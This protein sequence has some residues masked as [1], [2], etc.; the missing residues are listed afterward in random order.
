MRV[1]AGAVFAAAV[2]MARAPGAEPGEIRCLTGNARNRTDNF[3]IKG[4]YSVL[5]PGLAAP[6][7]PEGPAQKDVSFSRGIL[8]DG[9]EDTL[10][11]WDDGEFGSLGRDVVVDLGGEYFL[12]R[13]EVYCQGN[14][15]TGG[16]LSLKQEEGRVFVPVRKYGRDDFPTEADR[17]RGRYLAVLFRG[18]NSVARR[19]RVNVRGS[20]TPRFAE[21]QIWGRAVRAG[22]SRELR[23]LL[24]YDPAKLTEPRP[25]EQVKVLRG[26]DAI[27]PRPRRVTQRPGVFR[28]SAGPRVRKVRGESW[29]RP[30]GYK[31]AVGM[32][33]VDLSYFDGAGHVHGRQT[34]A[35][36]ASPDGAIPCCEII[37]W[38]EFDFRAV[39]KAPPNK[40]DGEF[41]ERY[42]RAVAALKYNRVVHEGLSWAVN[43]DSWKTR[44]GK[45]IDVTELKEAIRFKQSLGM[46]VTGGWGIAPA[47]WVTY[48]GDPKLVEARPGEAY[49]EKGRIKFRSYPNETLRRLSRVNAC[50]LQPRNFEIFKR[51]VD[52]LCSIYKDEY[53]FAGVDEPLQ[54]YNGSR[55]GCC[56]LCRGKDP[57]QLM[58]DWVNRC[59]D[60]V[61]RKHNRIHMYQTTIILKEHQG[62]EP[63]YPGGPKI[64]MYRIIDRM[65]KRRTA[66]VNW[67]Y[68]V[69]KREKG[70]SDSSGLN[71]Y[72]AQKGYKEI[73]Q[74]VGYTDASF[75]MCDFTRWARKGGADFIGATVA[76]YA[77]QSPDAMA[78][79]FKFLDYVVAAEELWSPRTP[80]PG[81]REFVSQLINGIEMVREIIGGRR[82]PSRSAGRDDFF[83]VDISRHANRGTV[84]E[85]AYD[86]RGWLDLGPGLD[87]RALSGGRKELCGWPFELLDPQRGCIM[88]GNPKR[89]GSSLP[90]DVRGIAVDRKAASL[91][92]LHALTGSMERR[93][94]GATFVYR[95]RYADGTA[96]EFPV[97]YRVEAMEWLDQSAR[98]PG[99]MRTGWFLFG[100]RPA[101]L[102]TTANGRRVI[103]YAAEWVNPHPEKAVEAVDMILPEDSLAPGAALFAITGVEVRAR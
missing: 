6:G 76:N 9:K 60:H 59:S 54:W 10:L 82:L 19:I 44:Y 56:E 70:E 93:S 102:G 58:A 2:F 77:G 26:L 7:W 49:V 73:I 98:G 36:I 43:L 78:R 35:Q 100:A 27:V 71:R 21:L 67:S 89:A 39:R 24:P 12:D 33:G 85:K 1:F 99:D 84:D 86:G 96:A 25:V 66:L 4:R 65:P 103:L 37:D 62:E 97:R 53:F 64:P 92:F 30:G 75:A 52:E 48:L 3:R 55:W 51:V 83:A 17:K 15:L 45:A 47:T 63:G 81:S 14:R 31:L 28:G 42:V 13:V 5:M 18:V 46:K 74:N 79:S 57:V 61:R 72:L 32:R 94:T 20:H 11:E 23:P 29:A 80:E 38:P 16:T 101:W 68:G 50:P 40:R 91:I 8:T 88:I 34:L 41:N 22:D 87:L 90:G 95:I 69:W